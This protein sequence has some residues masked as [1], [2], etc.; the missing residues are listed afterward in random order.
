MAND[1]ND[2]NDIYQDDTGD[3]MC[4]YIYFCNEVNVV[5][6]NECE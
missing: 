6:V 4:K 2:V 3:N 5:V 1:R